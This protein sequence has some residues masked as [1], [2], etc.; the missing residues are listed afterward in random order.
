MSLHPDFT[1]LDRL[2]EARELLVPLTESAEVE[3]SDEPIA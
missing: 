3:E 1:L 2:E